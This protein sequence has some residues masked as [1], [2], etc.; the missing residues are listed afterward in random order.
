MDIAKS[1]EKGIGFKKQAL[2]SERSKGVRI[3]DTIKM[4]EKEK[5]QCIDGLWNEIVKKDQKE[6]L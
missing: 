3:I 1:I 2:R 6:G 4:N 5:K